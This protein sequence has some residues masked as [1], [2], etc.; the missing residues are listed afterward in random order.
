MT[1]MQKVLLGSAVA[2]FAICS[3]AGLF[4]Y[5]H[6]LSIFSGEAVENEVAYQVQHSMENALVMHQSIPCSVTL[7]GNDLDISTYTDT[8]GNSSVNIV[9]NDATI[10]NGEVEV[11]TNGVD[12]YMADMHLHAMPAVEAN[13]FS[14]AETD[15]DRGITGYLTPGSSL[16]TGFERGVN[17]GLQRAHLLPTSVNLTDEAMIIGC[18]DQGSSG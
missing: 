12:I 16:E 9:N 8:S 1:T 5:Y 6:G 11:S 10:L 13:V 2:L 14:L 7:R 4:L 3:G 17:E 18:V 15:I